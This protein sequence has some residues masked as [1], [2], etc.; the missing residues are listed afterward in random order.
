M[1][2]SRSSISTK[3][4]LLACC[5]CLLWSASARSQDISEGVQIH[6]F[7]SQSLVHTTDNNVGGNSDDDI[8]WDLRE[9]GA[10]LSWR[11]SP[12]WLVS[13]QALA[14]WAGA[15]DEGDLR[16]DYGFVDH[17]FHADGENQYGIRLG[18]VK[19][20][21]GFFN[22]TRDVAHTRPGILLP[23]AVYIDE[24]RNTFL[25]APGASLNGI[26]FFEDSQLEWTF[27][28]VRPEVD[29]KSLTRYMATNFPGHFEGRTSWLG[30]ALWERDGG[31]WRAGLTLG[32]IK[33][34][35]EPASVR[36]LAP[37]RIALHTGVLSLE[38][39]MASWSLTGEYARINQ[40]RGGFLPSVP[41]AALDKDTTVEAAYLQSSW[42]FRPRW[43]AYL[44]YEV[45]YLD[46]NDR[47][48]REFQ[49]L[50][51]GAGVPNIQRFSRD[52]VVGL[53]YDP[54]T[55]WALSAE[56]HDVDGTAWLPRIDNPAPE[57]ER[58]WQMLLLQ[59]AWR[60]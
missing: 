58:R 11:P 47:N 39:N 9:M 52:K 28:A 30:Q 16:L 59:A 49:S 37:G 32:N 27:N 44:R 18:K 40:I 60:F 34:A 1:T 13:P 7:V 22:T 19:N 10:N 14:R 38:R 8:A 46:R 26:H 12:D 15:S 33:M 50:P 42:R 6:G 24:L 55:A 54:T 23:Q 56:F 2:R 57:M 29:A 43:R 35:Y 41:N 5:G 45:L 53:R 20:P 51:G 21:Y 4:C 48:G 31:S 36:D 17:T 3:S 25:A